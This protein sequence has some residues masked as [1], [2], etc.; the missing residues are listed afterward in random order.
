MPKG[1]RKEQ[2][3]LDSIWTQKTKEDSQSK[4]VTEKTEGGKSAR[5]KTGANE[6]G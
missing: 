2:K 5:K 6:T 4:G 1:W 3:E